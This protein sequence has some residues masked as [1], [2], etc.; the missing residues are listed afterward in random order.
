MMRMRT[1]SIF[2]LG[3]RML[4]ILLIC[5]V[6]PSVVTAQDAVLIPVAP[7]AGAELPYDIPLR[8]WLVPTILDLKTQF[9]DGLSAEFS[10]IAQTQT[11]EDLTTLVEAGEELST[12]TARIRKTV[13]AIGELD[14]TFG[15]AG[16]SRIIPAESALRDTLFGFVVWHEFSSTPARGM[17]TRFEG[18]V[19]RVTAGGEASADLA[20]GLA[21]DQ[22]QL[23]QAVAQGN[24]NSI[25]ELAPRIVETSRRI[26]AVCA[27]VAAGTHDLGVLV[28][29]LSASSGELL[30]EKWAEAS[31]AVAT[32]GEPSERT[33]PA[34][35]SMSGV[36]DLLVELGKLLEPSAS[37]VDALS[38]PPAADGD[39]YIPW[40]V[41]R[42][43]W[44][45]A[46]DLTERVLNEPHDEA[47]AG[48]QGHERGYM[49]G[50][51]SEE[52]RARIGALLAYQVEANA[53][54]AERAVEHMSTLVARAEDALE[55][56][57]C[58]RAG[59]SDD[60]D[61]RR[62]SAVLEQVD[63]DLRKSMELAAA[64]M[65]ARAARAALDRGLSHDAPGAG[66]EVDALHDYHNAWLHS[67]NAGASAQRVTR[68]VPSR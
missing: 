21:A 48:E 41:M 29:S 43:D 67:L 38:A 19:D 3:L 31:R 45:L 65:S 35:E 30:T 60:L 61:E 47:A 6:T 32:S 10:M 2:S 23:E 36:L 14:V 9:A 7:P 15:I 20:A 17:M 37:S 27:T 42:S 11:G 40:T 4:A 64:K 66:G 26:D 46:R 52:A 33:G 68:A 51:A 1:N 22:R 54:L 8:P 44:E 12:T 34:L 56:L 62:K 57:Y 13:T 39:L 59:Y 55:R 49:G 25:A 53:M 28:D 5:A 16:I 50:A 24:S 58:D 18:L 63:R